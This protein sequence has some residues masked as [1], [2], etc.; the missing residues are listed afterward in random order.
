MR[1]KGD[2]DAFCADLRSKGVESSVEP[3]DNNPTTRLAFIKAPDGVRVDLRSR[4]VMA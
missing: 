2:F 3:G 4:K 1:V